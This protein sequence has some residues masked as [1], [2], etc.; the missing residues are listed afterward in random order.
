MKGT[1]G[2]ALVLLFQAALGK[3]KVCGK[4]LN[5]PCTYFEDRY[6]LIEC[7]DDFVDVDCEFDPCNVPDYCRRGTSGP[8]G[9]IGS[10]GNKGMPGADGMVGGPGPAGRPGPQ[11]FPGVAGSK[12]PVGPAGPD[13]AAG[14]TGPNG[15]KGSTGLTGVQGSAGP[16]GP[17]G[18]PGPAGPQG[19]PVEGVIE[20]Y[21][22]AYSTI[23]QTIPNDFTFRINQA[24]I[25]STM[26]SMSGT[27]ELG[28]PYAGIL[29][30]EG[31]WYQVSFVVHIGSPGFVGIA[32]NGTVTADRTFQVAA[33]NLQIQ[34][35]T[36]SNLEPY[37][38]VSLKHVN[39]TNAYTL[40]I[41]INAALNIEKY[42][43]YVT[44]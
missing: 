36:I 44:P 40:A 16:Q 26:M 11:G 3:K 37:T 25:L 4:P 17:E 41:A 27:T 14:A 39:D 43:T 1:L 2:L 19:P 22:Y 24:G 20:H 38:L 33:G 31:G 29:V 35:F 13:G 7:W 8:K 5:D 34:G 15:P 23:I 28:D 42:G 18:M 6:Q 9:P 21:G 32:Y 12:G 30:E 10:T